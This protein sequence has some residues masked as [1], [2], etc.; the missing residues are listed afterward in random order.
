MVE[1]NPILLDLAE[2]VA[3]VLSRPMQSQTYG[4]ME[5]EGAFEG[6]T[7][8]SSRISS[9]CEKAL[10]GIKSGGRNDGIVLFM[11]PFV[12]Y[13]RLYPD[14]FRMNITKRV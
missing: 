1:P 10:E 13:A 11:T 4:S 12:S 2:E 14:V 3:E 6:R 8:Q 7:T 5:V 9:L